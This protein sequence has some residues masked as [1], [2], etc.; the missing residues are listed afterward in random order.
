MRDLV[1]A[2]GISLSWASFLCALS[3]IAA[4]AA[5]TDPIAQAEAYKKIFGT[6]CDV[7]RMGPHLN[8]CGCEG[9]AA[10]AIAGNGGGTPILP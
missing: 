6:C 3:A 7:D 1:G 8:G 5:I 9:G 10:T 4:I 2:H